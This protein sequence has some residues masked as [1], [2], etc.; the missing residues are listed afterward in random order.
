MT[1]ASDLIWE[2]RRSR[3]IPTGNV[4]YVQAA[5]RPPCRAQLLNV[6]KHGALITWDCDRVPVGPQV[7][8]VFVQHNGSLATTL[9]RKAVVLRRS[10]DGLGL[11]FIAA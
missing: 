11:K 4:L 2:R 8:L 5:G 9:R 1:G 10:R 6:S 3:R 7:T